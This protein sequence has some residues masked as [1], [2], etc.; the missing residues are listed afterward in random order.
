M[1]IRIL[2]RAPGQHSTGER[3]A[4]SYVHRGRAVWVS[5]DT[6]RFIETDSRHVAVCQRAGGHFIPTTIASIEEIRNLPVVRDPQILLR[7][8][9]DPQLATAV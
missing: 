6:I 1:R 3:N 5:H 7:G 9:Y 4:E 8:K 2:G